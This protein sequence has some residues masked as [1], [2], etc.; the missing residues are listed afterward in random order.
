MH[1]CWDSCNKP[2]GQA[3]SQETT[4]LGN[5]KC[6]PQLTYQNYFLKGM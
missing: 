1:A 5:D 4:Q 3:S 2:N 6:I